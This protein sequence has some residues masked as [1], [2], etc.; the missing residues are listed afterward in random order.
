MPTTLLVIDIQRGAFDGQRCPPI[1]APEP[2]LDRARALVNAARAGAHPIIFVQHCENKPGKVLEE[3]TPHGLLHEA[4]QPDPT[5]G[6]QER[7]LKKHASSAFENTELDAWLRALGGGEA[8]ELLVC[9]LQSELCVSNTVRSALALGYAVHLAEDAH[10]TWPS[11]DRSAAEIRAE[12]NAQL[13]KA[14]ARL[15]STEALSAR[16]SRGSGSRLMDLPLP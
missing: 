5:R 7:I 6:A 10:N 16:L 9:G 1:D 14:G 13:A 3:G 11:A 8:P 12:V 2:F 4:L 15:T